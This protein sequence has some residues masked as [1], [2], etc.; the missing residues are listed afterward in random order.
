METIMIL[1]NNAII[2]HFFTL[3]R[4]LG[5][6]LLRRGG[7]GG[8][9]TGFRKDSLLLNFKNVAKHKRLRFVGPGY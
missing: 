9:V 1:F 8:Q 3:L 6:P 7:F 4:H 2:F 5:F